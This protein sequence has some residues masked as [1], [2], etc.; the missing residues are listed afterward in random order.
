MSQ[1]AQAGDKSTISPGSAAAA[2]SLTAARSVPAASSSLSTT[3]ICF[4]PASS[5]TLAIFRAVSPK[6][7]TALTRSDN[8]GTSS[9]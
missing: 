5:D 4:N 8:A 1:L 3:T 9:M 6:A 7:M 2:A